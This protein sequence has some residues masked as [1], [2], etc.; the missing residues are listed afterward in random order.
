MF[1]RTTGGAAGGGYGAL[2]LVLNFTLPSG[3]CLPFDRNCDLRSE[4]LHGEPTPTVPVQAQANIVAKW[5]ATAT[6]ELLFS[7]RYVGD[8]Q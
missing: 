1:F 2:L 5:S 7:I 6:T 8:H 4:A 3:H